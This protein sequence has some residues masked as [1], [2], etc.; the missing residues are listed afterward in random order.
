MC[1][2]GTGEERVLDSVCFYPRSNLTLRSITI[3]IYIC[4]IESVSL[5]C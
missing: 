5:S 3:Y 1:E 4:T 2:V